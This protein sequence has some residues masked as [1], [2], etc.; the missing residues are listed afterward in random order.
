MLDEILLRKDVCK[1]FVDICNSE[2]YYN[3]KINKSFDYQMFTDIE[4][5]L[6]LFYDALFKYKIIIDDMD[7]FSEY[8]E[9]IDKLIRKI[10]NFKDISVGISRILT[11][12]CSLKLGVKDLDSSES[13]ESI[14]KYIYDVYIK[15]GYYMHGFASIYTNTIKEEG[16]KTECYNNLY[17]KFMKV[18]KILDRHNHGN[19]LDKDF[20]CKEI[21]LTDS[22]VMGCYYSVNAPMYFYKLLCKN[23]FVTRKKEL[24]C[25]L[26]SDYKSCYKNLSKMC[27]KMRLSDYD[28]NVFLDAFNSE[29]QL[30]KKEKSKISI[31]L[32]PRKLIDKE[33]VDYKSFIDDDT[34]LWLLVDKMINTKNSK[35][36]FKGYFEPSS[37]EFIELDYVKVLKNS[38]KVDTIY[39]KTAEIHFDEYAFSNAYGKVSL[40]VILGSLFVTLGVIITIVNILGGI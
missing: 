11:R 22:F 5:I 15:N 14:I 12:I 30:L 27:N 32:V 8:L 31:M 35:I 1:M 4:Q 36:K 16:F 10:D 21:S 2:C 23:E 26:R 20:N 13:R 38:D 3:K 29:W 19:I 24:D 7:Y 40:L 37:V 9:Q 33:V 6:F 39:D 25:Y 34:S 18:Q 28:K 17:P